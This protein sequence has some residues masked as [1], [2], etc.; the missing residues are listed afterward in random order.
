MGSATGTTTS[1]PATTAAVAEPTQLA[2][3]K[4]DKD[5]AQRHAEAERHRQEAQDAEEEA[6]SKCKTAA[7]AAAKHRAEQ[8]AAEK[9]RIEGG[10]SCE[11]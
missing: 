10:C 11:K 8:E 9:R 5:I 3:S 2:P 4:L 6:R 1:A 7:L